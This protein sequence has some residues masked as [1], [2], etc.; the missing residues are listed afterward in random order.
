M[1]NLRN[2]N[3]SGCPIKDDGLVN[4]QAVTNLQTLSLRGC[5]ITDAGLGALLQIPTLK[6]VDLGACLG[7]SRKAVEKFQA[8]LAERR[9]YPQAEQLQGG[10][11]LPSFSFP[12]SSVRSPQGGAVGSY[13]G[14]QI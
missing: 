7:L 8:A 6:E 9:N 5:K 14:H 10:A 3:L 11:S 1:P 12:S 4:L 2:L 13:Q